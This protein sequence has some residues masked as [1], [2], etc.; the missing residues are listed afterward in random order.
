MELQGRECDT[1]IIVSCM[2]VVLMA[3]IYSLVLIVS[4]I[5]GNGTPKT[6][7]IL[8]FLFLAGAIGGS[9][10][11]YNVWKDTCKK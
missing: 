4:G 1:I 9:I 10:Y 5:R 11:A 6:D 2:C 8:A 3:L 7:Y